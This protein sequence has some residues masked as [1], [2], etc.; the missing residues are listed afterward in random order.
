LV[1]AG[2]DTLTDKDLAI[3]R[4]GAMSRCEIGDSPHRGIL[5]VI[6]KAD[7]AR[8]CIPLSNADPKA[9]TPRLTPQPPRAFQL[10][11]SPLEAQDQ[12]R[13]RDR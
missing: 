13:E 10:P 3:A 12:G 4:G 11:D 9:A 7:V 1:D 2:C 5:D 6:V 8:R